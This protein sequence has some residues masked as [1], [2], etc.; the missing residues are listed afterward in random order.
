MVYTGDVIIFD[1]P[2]MEILEALIMGIIEAKPTMDLG[3]GDEFGQFM[4]QIAG[5]FLVA[6]I[7]L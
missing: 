3:Q 7:L 2:F 5:A 6:G 4:V 1:I